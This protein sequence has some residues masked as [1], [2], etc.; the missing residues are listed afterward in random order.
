MTKTKLTMSPEALGRYLWEHGLLHD[1]LV[2]AMACT[3]DATVTLS[4]DDANANFRGLPEYPG[5]V[6]L[7][8]TLHGVEAPVGEQV[9]GEH[10]IFEADVI[11]VSDREG[12]FALV[13]S[14]APAGSIAFGF[15][16]ATITETLL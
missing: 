2:T 8:L 3:D 13:V 16:T 7:R 4:I 1:G 14:F 12:Q 9:Q 5:K 10:T 15:A 6:S 11:S